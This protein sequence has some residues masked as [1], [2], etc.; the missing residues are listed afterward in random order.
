MNKYLMMALAMLLALGT[1]WTITSSA[2]ESSDSVVAVDA[3]PPMVV[4]VSTDDMISEAGAKVKQVKAV[5]ADDGA[6]SLVKVMA[7]ALALAQLL[8]QL[9]KTRLFLSVYSKVGHAGK[10]A[11]VSVCSVITTL[12]PLLQAG[13][14]LPL[15]LMS[16]GVL[17]A[18]MIAGHQLSLV[19]WPK[20]KP[21]AA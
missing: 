16:G 13:V 8:I 9:T 3:E 15:A 10:L 7:I 19:V 2:Q 14:S 1:M 17:S 5:L 20:K 11:I 21:A 6:S 4:E 12:V 18:V